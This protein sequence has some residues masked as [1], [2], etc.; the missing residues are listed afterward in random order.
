MVLLNN[1]IK[2]SYDAKRKA[3]MSYKWSDFLNS[4][5]VVYSKRCIITYC[6]YVGCILCCALIIYFFSSNSV[7]IFCVYSSKHFFTTHLFTFFEC[8]L[9]FYF[10]PSST[11]FFTVLF[12]MIAI[13]VMV[14]SYL[15]FFKIRLVKFFREPGGNLEIF[16][17]S[18][19][20]R[21][22]TMISKNSTYKFCGIFSWTHNT[23]QHW[24]SFFRIP[25]KRY[26]LWFSLA[27][28]RVYVNFS[29]II[30]FLLFLIV[31]HLFNILFQ[32]ALIYYS[33]I[34]RIT[35]KKLLCGH[36]GDTDDI[37]TLYSHLW[38]TF[39]NHAQ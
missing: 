31:F 17:E 6:L 19:S 2:G 37:C 7:S 11:I 20:T 29:P 4:N 14:P 32:R 39:L 9:L 13:Y 25:I 26:I 21:F 33:I 10:M 34:V 28:Y 23:L 16:S 3:E 30:T 18:L 8:Y 1:R 36:F 38:S 24:A 35:V 12:Y 15:A 5:W 22:S 27:S